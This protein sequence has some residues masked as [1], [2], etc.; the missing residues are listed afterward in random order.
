MASCSEKKERKPVLT[1]SIN[2]DH[3]NHLFKEIEL[4]GKDVGIV[5]IYSKYPNYDFEIEPNEGFTCVDDVARA[6]VMLSK[7]LE[8]NENDTQVLN[9]MK[10]LTEFVL[11]MQ[12]ENG[13]FNN[14]IWND[15]SI[16][17]TYKTS[18]AELNWWS[19]R[20]LWGL[21]SAYNLLKSDK[22]LA[23]RI[24][25][26]SEKLLANIKR[27]IQSTGPRRA[28]ARE[29]GRSVAGR[30]RGESRRSRRVSRSG[31]PAPARAP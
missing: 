6:I 30:R 21:E 26:A 16:N 24:A 15:L 13:Y 3:F 5:H 2:L 20:A 14:F 22:D 25:L 1:D 9:K 23:D 12:N 27:D 19:F 8:E 31:C 10:L 18:V 11:Q 28:S 4:N 7:Y 17:K 29:S